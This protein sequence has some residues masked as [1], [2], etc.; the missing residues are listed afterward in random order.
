MLPLSRSNAVRV[1]MIAPESHGGPGRGAGARRPARRG[2][3]RQARGEGPAHGAAGRPARGGRRDGRRGGLAGEGP[4]HG[5]GGRRAGG[6]ASVKIKNKLEERAPPPAHHR[7]GVSGMRR[8]LRG[9]G[10]GIA[11][12]ARNKG[13]VSRCRVDGRQASEERGRGDGR[14]RG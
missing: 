7:A 5:T 8:P 6:R 10:R 9:R 2:T 3:G 12:A 1:A 4:G 14:W 11:E 13:G